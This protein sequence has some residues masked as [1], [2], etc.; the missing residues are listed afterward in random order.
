MQQLAPQGFFG[1]LLGHLNELAKKCPDKKSPPSII[2][3]GDVQ[4]ISQIGGHTLLPIGE[5]E[6]PGECF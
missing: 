3:M 2:L 1:N 5:L 6:Q 4:Q